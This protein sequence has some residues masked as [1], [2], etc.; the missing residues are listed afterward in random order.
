MA[1]LSLSCTVTQLLFDV[2]LHYVFSTSQ[3]PRG[4]LQRILAAA[5]GSA[6]LSAARSSS[7]SSSS[8][9]ANT[10]SGSNSSSN[11]VADCCR[12]PL[13]P[14]SSSA[15]LVQVLQCHAYLYNR[16]HYCLYCTNLNTC[17]CIC[18]QQCM[19]THVFN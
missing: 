17:T 18:R 13:P 16:L 3:D 4:R 14:V 11:D 2:I 7:S 15:M 5:F 19:H 12:V 8:S 9:S 10:D 6:T 1:I